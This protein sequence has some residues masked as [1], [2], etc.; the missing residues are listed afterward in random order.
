MARDANLPPNQYQWAA[1]IVANLGGHPGN[2]D[3]IALVEAW[4]SVENVNPQYY[5]PLATTLPMPGAVSFNAAG[6]KAYPDY[7]T[8]LT[9]TVDTLNEYPVLR[10]AIIEGN[11]QLFFSAA[12]RQ[13]LGEWSGDSGAA[14][15]QYVSDIA[16]NYKKDT[17]NPLQTIEAGI[18]NTVSSVGHAASSVAQL[19]GE[20]VSGIENWFSKSVFSR[21]HIIAA[22]ALIAGLIL[23]A[24][25]VRDL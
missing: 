14:L 10:R 12:G 6:V 9:A 22:L 4:E 5:N 15:S 18:G 23:L 25:L 2:L 1:N 3:S 13:E 21:D 24:R 19:P 17:G 20:W 16:S 11:P 7:E 8:G